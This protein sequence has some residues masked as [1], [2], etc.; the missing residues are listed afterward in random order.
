MKTNRDF[1]DFD[2]PVMTG[3]STVPDLKT[4]TDS[5]FKTARTIGIK[6]K[7]RKNAISKLDSIN[8]RLL[9]MPI[10]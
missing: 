1:V 4:A 9:Y 8:L 3:K 10:D 2:F 6:T 5:V 7:T